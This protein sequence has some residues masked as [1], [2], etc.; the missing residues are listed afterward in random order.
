MHTLYY[1]LYDWYNFWYLI[2]NQKTKQS[3]SQSQKSDYYDPLSTTYSVRKKT[4]CLPIISNNITAANHSSI[5]G[6]YGLTIDI[7]CNVNSK[8]ILFDATL[9]EHIG[10]TRCSLKEEILLA[11]LE[12]S[13]QAI[14]NK[15]NGKKRLTMHNHVGIV[16]DS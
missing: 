11:I 4:L 13:V 3:T 9:T 2:L 14:T 7:T 5:K 10:K 6:V 8:R 1:M 15:S 12:V 16:I